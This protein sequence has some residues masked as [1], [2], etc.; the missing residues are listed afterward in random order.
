MILLIGGLAYLFVFLTLVPL[1]KIVSVSEL[2]GLSYVFNQFPY[3]RT[4]VKPII[5]YLRILASL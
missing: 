1:M 3:V 4:I 2:D 5:S